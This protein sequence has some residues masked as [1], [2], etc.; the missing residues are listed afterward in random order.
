V[1]ITQAK[2]FTGTAGVLERDINEWLGSKDT[3]GRNPHILDVIQSGDG[4]VATVTVLY[5]STILSLANVELQNWT[6][7]RCFDCRSSTSRLG[8][9]IGLLPEDGINEWLK[10]NAR[11]K[12]RLTQSGNDQYTIFIIWHR[13]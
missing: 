3:H 9:L 8:G 5:L 2:V 4:L 11:A 1:N 6:G 13:G 10:E 7:V 12:F